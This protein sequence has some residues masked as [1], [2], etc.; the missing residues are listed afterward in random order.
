MPENVIQTKSGIMVNVDEEYYIWNPSTCS[1]KSGKY[2]AS[3]IDDSLIT[4][5]EIIDLEAK[6]KH[7]ET[8]K[9]PTNFNEQKY[10]L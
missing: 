6:S 2:F 8:K 5:D 10:N 4:C 3:I 7:E 1:C 9:V